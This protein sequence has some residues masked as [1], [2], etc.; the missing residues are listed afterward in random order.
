M[1]SDPQ[2]CSSPTSNPKVW[3]IIK[4]YTS[5]VINSFPEVEENLKEYLGVLCHYID[6]RDTFVAVEHTEMDVTKVIKVI[7]ELSAKKINPPPTIHSS[8]SNS[9]TPCPSLPQL[10]RLKQEI[11]KQV[12]QLQGRGWV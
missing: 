6:W 8:L 2:P 1:T 7:E 9:H 12:S 3:A 11:T 4:D 5:S 10:E